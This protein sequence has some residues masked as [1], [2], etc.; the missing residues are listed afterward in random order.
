[1]VNLPLRSLFIMLTGQADG[2]LNQIMYT[3]AVF[4]F[5]LWSLDL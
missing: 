3:I 1:M 4:V 5:G 2:S